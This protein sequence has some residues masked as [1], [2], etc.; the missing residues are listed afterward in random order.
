MLFQIPKNELTGGW[1]PILGLAWPPSN[2][3]S[4]QSLGPEFR[5][6]T[7]IGSTDNLGSLD[8]LK[9]ASSSFWL[10][11]WPFDKSLWMALTTAVKPW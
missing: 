9:N 10:S 4:G 1:Q 7:L 5:S 11:E 2:S 3:A 6:L 8:L